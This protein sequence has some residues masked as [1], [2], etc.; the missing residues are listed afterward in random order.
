MTSA[1]ARA[2]RAGEEF[3]G[4]FDLICDADSVELKLGME[5]SRG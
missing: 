2:G 4:R 5:M 1:G 3:G